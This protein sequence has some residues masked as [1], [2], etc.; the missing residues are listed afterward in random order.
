MDP[1]AHGIGSQ[2]SVIYISKDEGTQA[3]TQIV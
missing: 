1:I 2:A 3:S